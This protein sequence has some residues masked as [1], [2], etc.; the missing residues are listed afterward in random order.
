VF[1]D[2]IGDSRKAA[3]TNAITFPVS[4]RV[5]VRAAVSSPEATEASVAELAAECVADHV[6]SWDPDLGDRVHDGG[7]IAE[8]VKRLKAVA[9]IKAKIK[10]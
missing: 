6:Q 10:E 3:A 9:K 4:P 8:W 7:K 1:A 2:I 5:L